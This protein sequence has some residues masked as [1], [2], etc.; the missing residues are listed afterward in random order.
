MCLTNSFQSVDTAGIFL[1]VYRSAENWWKMGGKW[2]EN[3]LD[4]HNLA[5][6]ALSDN[7]QELK[8]FNLE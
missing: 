6:T 7:F 2:V 4:L 8:V 1:S 5:K 3:L